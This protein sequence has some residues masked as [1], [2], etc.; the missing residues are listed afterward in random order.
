MK[1]LRVEVTEEDIKAGRQGDAYRCPLAR[2]ASRADGSHTWWFGETLAGRDGVYGHVS[3]A[4][5][6][7]R[8]REAFDDRQ[9]VAPFVFTILIPEPL[10]PS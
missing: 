6:V 5:R 3:Q 4:P 7:R 10:E 2:A 9:K 1:R 8:W